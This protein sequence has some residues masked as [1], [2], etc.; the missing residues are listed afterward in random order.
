MKKKILFIVLLILLFTMSSCKNESI[1]S[2]SSIVIYSS[3]EE[4][5]NENMQKMLNERFPE[6]E[7]QILYL[8]TGNNAAKIKSEGESVEADIITGL[9]ASFSEEVKN[10]FYSLDNFD[11]SA[12]E[13]DIIP[14]HNKYVPF[15]RESESI[16]I[17]DAL[18]KEKGL[19][20]P[21][22]YEDLLNPEYKGLISMPN[23]K[24][25]STGYAFLLNLANEWGE[26][27][28]FKYFDMLS[29]NILQYT[30]SG[31]GPVNAL[32]Q[33]ETVIGLGMTF[34]AVTEI[35]NGAPLSIH[36]FKEGS[37]WT[38]GTCAIINGKENKDGVIEVFNYIVNE[39]SKEDKKLFAPEPIFKEQISEVENYPTVIPYANMN[40]DT[41]ARKEE[42]L[43]MWMH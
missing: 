20:Y 30:S 5:R 21:T 24:T 12:F 3:L 41:V 2:D 1:G 7:I 16:I 26:E 10:N 11:Y 13:N 4:Y 9:N 33:G 36:Y 31:S 29:E 28:A 22:K 34:Q 17:N 18:I 35:N 14:T 27:K 38:F 8:S 43:N 25:S 19:N 15:A 37:P 39:V 23:P 40:N 6:K 32:V 42:L